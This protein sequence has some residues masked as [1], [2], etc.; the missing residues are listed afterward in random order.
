MKR[1]VNLRIVCMYCQLNC[2]ASEYK[3]YLETDT[4]EVFTA[5]EVVKQ[6]LIK[7][8]LQHDLYKPDYLRLPMI[9]IMDIAR[10]FCKTPD[11]LLPFDVTAADFEEQFEGTL[12]HIN[13]DFRYSDP[14]WNYYG[15]RVENMVKEWCNMNNYV[16][17]EGPSFHRMNHPFS[18]SAY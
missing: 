10:E 14:W 5:D 3:Y 4:N 13:C 6:G 2:E 16:Y 11:C 1:T 9:P 8:N 15:K 7:L 12:G 17:E 18:R